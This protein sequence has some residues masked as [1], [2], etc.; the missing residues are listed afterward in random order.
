MTFRTQIP[1]EKQ[2]HHRIDYSSKLVLFGSCFSENIGDK[3]EYYKF[4]TAVNPF[5]ILFHPVAIEQLITKAV[6]QSEYSEADLIENNGLWFSFDAHSSLSASNSSEVVAALNNAV[7]HTHEQLKS[8]SH[9]IITLGT[10]WVY[11]QIA[12]DRIVANCHKVPQKQFLK[13]LL[14]V[15]E[16]VSSL[17]ATIALLR[18]INPKVNVLLTVSPVRHLKD[19]FVENMTSKSHLIAAVNAIVEPRHKIFYFPA[20]EIMVDELRDYR[21]YNADMIHPNT[22]AID[23]IWEQ[24]NLAWLSDD[25][26]QIMSQVDSIQKRMAHK[27]FN[28]KTE[29]HQKFLSNLQK[30]MDSLVDQ[31]PFMNF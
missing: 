29:A 30:D 9:I 13:E 3:L 19:G 12:S 16:V 21:F 10:A 7:S 24:F 27:A 25:T 28:P 17:Q 15:D 26:K 5:G 1:I 8:A 2:S 14:S 20:Y 23:Y 4:Q 6:N 31:Y 18:D 22:T 11:R